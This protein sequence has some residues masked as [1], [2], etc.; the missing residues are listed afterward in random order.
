MN[1]I[2]YITILIVSGTFAASAY[3]QTSNIFR[4]LEADKPGQGKVLIVQDASIATAFEQYQW[5]Q[6]KQGGIE[7][8]RIRIFSDS[9]PQAKNRF[10]ETKARFI[11][12]FEG[13][14]VHES[15]IYPHYKLYVGD[16]RTRSEAL[17]MLVQ[18]DKVFPNVAFIVPSKI[19]YPNLKLE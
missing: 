19:N 6:S 15:F 1:K 4:D 17:K 7:G 11:N 14:T 2:I 8:F 13:I 18:I 10:D 16:F 9:G 5:E 12:H 3:G